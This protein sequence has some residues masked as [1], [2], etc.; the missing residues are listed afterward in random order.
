MRLIAR[1]PVK[2]IAELALPIP[3]L[4]GC[5]ASFLPS[6]TVCHTC[7]SARPRAEDGHD[8]DEQCFQKQLVFLYG[9]LRVREPQ[10]AQKLNEREIH[11]LAKTDCRK[12]LGFGIRLLYRAADQTRRGQETGERLLRSPGVP[13]GCVLRRIFRIV[14]NSFWHYD[15]QEKRMPR[16]DLE[17]CGGPSNRFVFSRQ[18]ENFCADVVLIA[19]RT[20]HELQWR[21]FRMHFLRGADWRY[22]CPKLNLDR[23][24]FFHE[25]Y[26]VEEALG[27]SFCETAP[28]GVYPVGEYFGSQLPRRG[29]W[30]RSAGKW[31]PS[32]Q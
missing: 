3:D 10:M 24:A 16:V 19:K 31:R 32:S 13:C 7:G 4:C 15:R 5:G 8:P 18:R 22:C 2:A 20:L 9:R 25:V 11:S 21:L 12:C 6:F 29:L 17:R 26:R 28:Y 30:S 14:M 23:G 27:R 1:P